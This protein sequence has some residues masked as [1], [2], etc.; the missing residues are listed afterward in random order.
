MRDINKQRDTLR[1]S[2]KHRDRH[3]FEGEKHTH[4]ERDTN[5]HTKRD[6]NTERKYK[7]T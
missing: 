3:T 1:D 4:I 5:S 6:T 7:D 2:H